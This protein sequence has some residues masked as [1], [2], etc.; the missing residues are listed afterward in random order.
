[1]NEWFNFSGGSR[2]I[3]MDR[4][5]AIYESA[6]LIYGQEEKYDMTLTISGVDF[7]T[8]KSFLD[9]VADRKEEVK[10]Y[11]NNINQ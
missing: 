9:W 8:G 10:I 1:M 7:E 6:F 4:L 2:K 11:K 3:D 5:E